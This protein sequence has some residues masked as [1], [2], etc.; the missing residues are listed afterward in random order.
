MVS[1]LMAEDIKR[2]DTLD[3]N[4]IHLEKEIDEVERDVSLLGIMLGKVVEEKEARALERGGGA[5]SQSSGA[6]SQS[7]QDEVSSGGAAAD[8]VREASGGQDGRELR[9]APSP[10]PGAPAETAGESTVRIPEPAPPRSSGSWFFGKRG[11]TSVRNA[12]HEAED[13]ANGSAN[14]SSRPGTTPPSGETGPKNAQNGLDQSTKAVEE[15]TMP[16]DH[17]GADDA[18]AAGA[19]SVYGRGDLPR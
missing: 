3:E 4:L 7:A 13:G 14:S 19:A 15:P 5:S 18:G 12:S 11:S 2:T 16:V 1:R 8:G 17:A 10:T 6:V 9:T